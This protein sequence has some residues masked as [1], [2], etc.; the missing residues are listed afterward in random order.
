MTSISE[1]VYFVDGSR[2]P[3]LRARGKRGPFSASDLAVAAGAPLLARQ[4]FAPDALDEVVLGCAMP[5]VDEAN[6]ARV[7]ALRLGCGDRVPAYTVMRNC[8]SAMEALDGAAKDIALGRCDLVLAGGTEA[9]S[10]APLLFQDE[11]VDWL[12]GLSAARDPLAKL[13][14]AAKLRPQYLKPVIG[15]LRGLTDPLVGL[16]M[17]QTCELI[18]HRFGITRAQMDA[19]AVR[20]HQALARAYD[21]GR[22]G[23]V[24]P[25]YD[26]AGHV[27]LEDDGLRRDSSEEKLAKL[28]PAFDRRIGL[29]TPGNSSQITDGA[30]LLILASERAVREHALPVIGRLVDVEWA[31]LDPS[32][33]GL[34]PVHAS[35][36]LVQ[37]HS[38]GLNDVDVWEINEA[39]AGQ[40]LACLAAWQDADYCRRE[41]G[42]DAPLGRLDEERLNVDGGAIALGHPVGA[43]GARIVLHALAALRQRDGRRAIATLCIGGGQGG[44][45]LLERVG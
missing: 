21:E 20:S 31:A 13:K 41:L 10:R 38:L 22:M 30:A 25:L 39:F 45:M 2:T 16:N 35:T 32:Q 3:F 42:L 7:V 27:Y 12:G 8:A 24:E 15:L 40:V 6:I 23:E 34:G 33:M 14:A 37:R 44:A 9:M 1:P 5:S 18:A 43:S 11:F 4:P 17:G 29:V 19:Y 28:K 26:A 36:P